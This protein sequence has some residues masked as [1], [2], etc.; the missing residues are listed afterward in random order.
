VVGRPLDDD[1]RCR[2]AQRDVLGLT[3]MKD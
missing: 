2:G 3:M 1:G